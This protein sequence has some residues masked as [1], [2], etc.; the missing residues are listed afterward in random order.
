MS[1]HSRNRLLN[2][3]SVGS[4]DRLLAHCTSVSL[5]LKTSLS[6]PEETPRFAF[7]M[8][9]GMTSLVTRMDDGASAEVNVVGFEGLVNSL[10]LLG[11]TPSPIDTFIQLAGEALR[12]PFSELRKAFRDTEEIRDRILEFVQS[13]AMTTAQIAGCSRLHEAE[14]RLAR[15]LLMA[16]DRAGTGDL[17]VTQE[18]LAM[19]LGARRTTV[20]LIA[21]TLQRAGLIEYHRGNVKI[22]D[23]ERLEAAA[24]DCYKV[25]HR[26]NAGLYST[27]WPGANGFFHPSPAVARPPNRPSA[28][29]L[30]VGND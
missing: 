2:C 10:H 18:F 13:Q 20:T 8:L 14:E 17:G 7:F 29:D 1:I 24:C 12:I 21:G 11:P 22:L 27:P 9:S 25:T 23:R 26:L 5:P 19:M 15:W 30:P 28:S 3:L 6:R 4:R 16:H